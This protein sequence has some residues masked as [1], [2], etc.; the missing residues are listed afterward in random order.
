VRYDSE[1]I[2]VYFFRVIPHL[3]HSASSFRQG[4][5]FPEHEKRSGKT[6]LREKP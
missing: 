5:Q 2:N 3:F 6:P 4:K 1:E